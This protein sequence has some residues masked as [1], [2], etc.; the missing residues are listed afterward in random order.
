MPA[1]IEASYAQNIVASLP[2]HI[3]AGSTSL[4]SPIALK[5]QVYMVSSYANFKGSIKLQI[6]PIIVI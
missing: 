2:Y 5:K 6:I 3:K 4:V 1:K